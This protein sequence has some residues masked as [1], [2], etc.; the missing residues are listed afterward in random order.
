MINEQVKFQRKI[1][2]IGTSVG[3]TLP[4]ELLDYL[5]IEKGSEVIM[6]GDSSKHGKFIAIWNKEQ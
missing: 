6:V 5:D 3:V 2:T 4:P 1:G